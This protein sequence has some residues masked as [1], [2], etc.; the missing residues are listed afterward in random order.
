MKKLGILTLM[1]C[2]LPLAVVATPITGSFGGNGW[3]TVSFTNLNFCP[4][5]ST[6]NGGNVVGACTPGTG[7]IALSGGAGSFAAVTGT[8]NQI[9][10]ISQAN[11]PVGTPIGPG[12]PLANFLVFTPEAVPPGGPQISITLTQVLAGTFS[13]GA[14]CDPFGVVAAG[15]TCTPSGSAFNLQN[16]TLT[17]S[18]ATFTMLG[19]AVDGVAGDASPIQIVFSGQFTVPYQQLLQA[20]LSNGGTGNYSGSY[21]IS[22]SAISG[23]PEPATLSLIGIGLLGIGFIRRRVRR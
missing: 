4:T 19:T 3:A 21:S 18:S 20:L 11:Q 22:E 10:S 15:Q 16:Q 12:L 13:G 23:V 2:G 5:G 17:T 9:K 1:A 14:S 7:V 6:P 8:V